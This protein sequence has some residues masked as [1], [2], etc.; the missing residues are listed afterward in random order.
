LTSLFAGVFLG[1]FVEIASVVD[2]GG[3][4]VGIAD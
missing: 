4:F 1:L 2:S 3:D